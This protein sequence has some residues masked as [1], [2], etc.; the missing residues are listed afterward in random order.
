APDLPRLI[1]VLVLGRGVEMKPFP[2]LFGSVRVDRLALVLRTLFVLAM[3]YGQ[4]RGSYERWDDMYGGPPAPG[5]GRGGVVSIRIEKKEPAKDDPATWMWLDFTS[6]KMVRIAG[7]KPP[8]TV[9]LINWNTE[10]KK[11]TL[12][13]FR[14]PEW[15][16]TFA[17]D[18][19]G[20]DELTLQG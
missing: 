4:F 2:P 15:S 19:S 7:P 14:K 16:A 6:R 10:G 8:N 20:P 5:A 9:Y 3:V 17:Y 1:H 18:L 12:S 13:T 11:L